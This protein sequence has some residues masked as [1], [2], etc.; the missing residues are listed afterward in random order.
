MIPHPA[1]AGAVLI[2]VA[3]AIVAAVIVGRRHSP[4]GAHAAAGKAAPGPASPTLGRVRRAARKWLPL[5][6]RVALVTGNDWVLRRRGEHHLGGKKR[7]PQP[8][9]GDQ[10]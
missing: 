3:V 10:F 6:V 1:I 4:P 7:P 2:V 9:P 8:T 5:S